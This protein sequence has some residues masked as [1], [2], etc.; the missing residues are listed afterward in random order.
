M[1]GVAPK[2]VAPA[3]LRPDEVFKKRGPPLSPE[4]IAAVALPLAHNN[5][6]LKNC[7][8]AG[9]IFEQALLDKSVNDVSRATVDVLPSLAVLP[10]PEAITEE[11][12]SE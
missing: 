4:Q 6:A 11:K 1:H 5:E 12:E 7:I 8:S 9:K 10:K 2:L 3:S